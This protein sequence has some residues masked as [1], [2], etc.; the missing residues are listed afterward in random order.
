MNAKKTT[1]MYI[2]IKE[3]IVKTARKSRCDL[4]RGKIRLTADS[5]SGT[6][7]SRR[8][9]KVFFKVLTGKKNPIVLEFY[10]YKNIFQEIRQMAIL[11][12]CIG[13]SYLLSHE[14]TPIFLWR[15]PHGK[16]WKPLANSSK[17]QRP[18]SDS[19]VKWG[20]RGPSSSSSQGFWWLQSCLIAWLKLMNQTTPL[21]YFWF[22]ESMI[23]FVILCKTNK[24]MNEINKKASQAYTKEEK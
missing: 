20:G 9:W 15:G 2:T 19:H 11:I 17:Q 16:E 10:S 23:M 4:Q 6:L 24:W 12:T 7:K 5:W 22:T 1:H 3:K 13:T 21:L 18:C 8:Q 14:Y